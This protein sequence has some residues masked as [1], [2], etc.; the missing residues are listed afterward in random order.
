LSD[1]SDPV[2][3]KA[4]EQTVPTRPARTDEAASQ[5][6]RPPQEQLPSPAVILPQTSHLEGAAQETPE[7]DRS[8]LADRGPR[9][10][11]ALWATVALVILAVAAIALFLLLRDGA[12][13]AD[14]P[15]A[16]PTSPPTLVRFQVPQE[17]DTV[18]SPFLARGTAELPP[19]TTLW[20]LT[21][22]ADGVYYPV[23][24]EPVAV[25]ADGRWVASVGIGRG[26]RDI[27]LAFDLHAVI[28]PASGS[29]LAEAVAQASGTGSSARFVS[30]PADVK[31]AARV[32]VIL[33]KRGP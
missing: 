13:T 29:S 16:A 25:D 30:L 22:P 19:N 4:A 7:F 20:L 17:G 3:H 11:L 12:L 32:H 24:A 33:G 21:Q 26:E 2:V 18:A 9:R 10:P 5:G 8:Q 27:G 6:F 31:T 14:R 28:A 15:S 23:G 1:P